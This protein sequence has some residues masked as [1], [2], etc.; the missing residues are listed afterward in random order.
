MNRE[1]IV[2]ALDTII[3]QAAHL[4]QDASDFKARVT[5]T[6]DVDK[7]KAEIEEH[8]SDHIGGMSFTELE[9]W[10]G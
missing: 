3:G 10:A 8:L 4:I 6:D 9:E 2:E 7:I 5:A 1:E